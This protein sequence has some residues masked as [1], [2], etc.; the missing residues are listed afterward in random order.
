MFDHAG[1][2]RF[3]ACTAVSTSAGLHI[4]VR[5]IVSPVEGLCTSV[6]AA[7]AG[8]LHFPAINNGTSLFCVTETFMTYLTSHWP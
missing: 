5:A 2:A 3:A 7:T 4:G 1:N 8:L 6:Y